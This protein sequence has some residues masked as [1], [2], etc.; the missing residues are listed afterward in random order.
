MLFLLLILRSLKRNVRGIVI[1]TKKGING[2]KNFNGY[3]FSLLMAI[4]QKSFLNDFSLK[5]II[6]VLFKSVVQ[7]QKYSNTNFQH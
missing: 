6:E 7:N 5:P 1:P 2:K 4:F 3:F